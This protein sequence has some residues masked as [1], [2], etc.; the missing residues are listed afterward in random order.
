MALSKIKTN[1]IADNAITSTKIGVDVIVAE[2]LASNSITVAEIAS[3]AV[4]TA[5]I[6]DANVT[7]DKLATTLTVTHALGSASTPSITFTGDTNTGIFSPTADTIAFAEGGTES[8]RITSDGNVGIGTTSP[9]SLGGTTLQVQNSTIGAIIWSDGTR[10]GELLASTAANISVGSR[11]NHALHLVTNDTERVRI[12]S[13]GNVGIGTTSPTYGTLEVAQG[14]AGVVS[15]INNTVGA[16]SF[17]KV[18]SD[19]SNGMGIYDPSGFGA[20]ALY[21][22]GSERLRIDGSGNVGIGTA[23]PGIKLQVVGN[24]SFSDTLQV[25]NT[26][27]TSAQGILFRNSYNVGGSIFST[28]PATTN[29]FIL[30]VGGSGTQGGITG[31]GAGIN[32]SSASD[33]RLKENVAPM[34]GALAKV[35]QLKPCTYTWKFDGSDGQGFIAHELQEVFP[36]AVTGEKDAVETYTDEDGNEQTKIKPQGVDTSFL[37]ATLAAAIQELKAEFDEYKRTHP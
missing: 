18:R 23:S 25:F 30:W 3:N 29:D 4:T 20:M 37:V 33:Y 28:G 15:V 26:P 2:D 27:S 22:A 5:K 16:W 36:D 14:S 1:S 10:I 24:G 31:N 17:R 12:T 32:Y 35:A 19:G 21:T 11:S 8:M 9:T 6:A 7:T 34:T 13:D